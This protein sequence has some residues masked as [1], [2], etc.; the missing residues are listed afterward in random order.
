MSAS[1]TIYA[2]N[3]SILF[4]LRLLKGVRR[5]SIHKQKCLLKFTMH[6]QEVPNKSDVLKWTQPMDDILIDALLSQQ[7]LGN[8]VDKVFTTTA[9]GFAWS[10]DTKTWTAKPEIWKALAKSKPGAKK[11]EMTTRIANYDKLLMLLAKDREKREGAKGS[12]LGSYTGGVFYGIPLQDVVGV[13]MED[14]DMND[15]GQVDSRAPSQS[16]TSSSRGEK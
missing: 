7:N 2:Y 4:Y 9:S 1:A 14:N 3:G 10:P 16:A 13:N 11:E 5:K 8:R 6:I 12:Q 15:T